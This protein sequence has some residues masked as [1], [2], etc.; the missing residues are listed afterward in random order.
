MQ[1]AQVRKHKQHRLGISDVS[2][3]NILHTF[4]SIS[5]NYN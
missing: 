2:K 3:V 5:L 4:Y 1:K